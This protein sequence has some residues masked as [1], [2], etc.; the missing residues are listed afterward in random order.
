[1][2]TSFAGVGYGLDLYP[3][4]KSDYSASM[5]T[6]LSCISKWHME[7]TVPIRAHGDVLILNN[8]TS[9]TSLSM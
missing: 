8:E 1:V 3:S 4:S 7:G 6:R 2:K 5:G 9:L